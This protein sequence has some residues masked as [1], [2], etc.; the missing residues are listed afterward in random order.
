MSLRRHDPPGFVEDLSEAN[1]DGWSAI[2]S[3]FMLTEQVSPILTPQFYDETK[4]V[5]ENPS[6]Y[7]VTWIGFPRKVKLAHPND[8]ERWKV[9]DSDRNLQDEYL[10]WS[11]KRNSDGKITKVVFSNE[12]PEYFSYLGSVQPDTLLELYRSLHP[13]VH[14]ANEDIFEQGEGGKLKYNPRNRWNRSTDTGTI[15]HL[16]QKNNTLGAE[17]NLGA[18]ATVVRKRPDGTIIT[19]SDELIKCSRYG[20]PDRNSDPQIGAGINGFARKGLMLTVKNPVGLYI[21]PDINLG[22]IEPPP[23][24]EGDDPKDFC[25]FTRGKSGNYVRVEFEV[26][27]GKPYVLGDLI[28]DNEPLQYGAQLADLI[29]VSI[30]ADATQLQLQPRSCS[31]LPLASSGPPPTCTCQKQA[32]FKAV[33]PVTDSHE[34]ER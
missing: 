25:R 23:G 19:D 27:E 20:N 30:T 5:V 21:E 24:H 12:G 13:G 22:V 4:V 26:P 3:G 6:S 9:A 28:V 33:V 7:K 1:K 34:H 17:I 18:R 32:A 31:E 29:K 11:I 15:M 2:I 10:E 8:L 14:I 16:I